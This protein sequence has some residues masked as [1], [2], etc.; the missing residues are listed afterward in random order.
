MSTKKDPPGTR[1]TVKVTEPPDTWDIAMAKIGEI[2][3]LPALAILTVAMAVTYYGVFYG[4]IAGDDLSFHMAESRRIADCIAAGDWDFWNPSANAGYASAYYYQVIPQL[5]SAL[6]AAIFGHHTF[7]FQLS[8]FL[9]LVLAPLAAYRG[10]RLMGAVPWQAV[11]A[12][13]VLSFTIGQSRWGFSADGTFSV[14]LYT[15][16]WALAAFPLALGYGVRWIR[17]STGIAPAIAWGAFVGLC[18]PFGGVSLGLSLALGVIGGVFLNRDTWRSPVLTA[19][20][21]VLFNLLVVAGWYVLGRTTLLWGALAAGIVVT[22]AGI[23]LARDF[24]TDATWR[25]SAPTVLGEPVRLVI[26]GIGLAIATM[27]G[28]ITMLIDAKGFGGFPHRVDD[29]V[30]PGFKLLGTWFYQGL[31]LDY[32]RVIV[33]T[34]AL[35]VAML[36]GRNSLL[37]WFW[38]PGIAFALLLGLGPHMPKTA[39]DLI[40]AVR[41]LG[42]MQIMFALGIGAGLYSITIALWNAPENGWFLRSIRAALRLTGSW[43]E[44]LTH[45]SL[46]YGVRTGI[47]AVVAALVVL[48]A[49]PG[50]RVLS[51]R[52]R[53]LGSDPPSV[54]PQMMEI[55]DALET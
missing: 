31:I 27:P 16:T 50:S 32:G 34:C 47:A 20:V 3:A 35:P 39:D 37:R 43:V 24:R 10:M 19:V 33:L 14:G 25:T 4:E 41:F 9:P 26:L 51:G 15:Q 11:T 54:R 13:F 45:T 18:H 40:P 23:R 7:F 44:R 48:V 52:V 22:G 55:I 5:A 12:A 53:V 29:E 17:E 42:S 8:V 36:F 38:I 30:G 21:A 2:G 49:V 46:Q 28:W 6:P 1:T